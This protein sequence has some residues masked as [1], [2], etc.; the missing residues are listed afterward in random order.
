VEE[1]LIYDLGKTGIPSWTKILV[2]IQIIN[3]SKICF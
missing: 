3:I 2:V 1:T